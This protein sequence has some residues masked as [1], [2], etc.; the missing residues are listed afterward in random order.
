LKLSAN[1]P[2]VDVK[3]PNTRQR[4]LPA[5]TGLRFIAAL[6]VFFGH[7]I[8]PINPGNPNLAAPFRDDGLTATLITLT[9]PAT[10]MAM[11]LF[12][13]LS[14]FVIT[15]SFKP[16]QRTTSFWRRRVVKIFPS[17]AVTWALCMLLFAGAYTANYG[18]LNLF[19]LDTW[20]NE[21][22]LWGGANGPAWSLNSE[23][24]FYLLIPLLLLP[25][26][27][28]PES[29]L[30]LSAGVLVALYAGACLFAT[31]VIPD[32]PTYG[33]E[34]SIP[35]FWFVYFFPPMRMFEFLLGVLV[36][37]I[38]M[39]GRWPRIPVAIVGALL[40]GSYLLIPEVP[41][42]YRIALV[43]LVPIALAIG[44]L[45]SANLRGRRTVLGTGPM[46]W[47]GRVSFGFYMTQSAVLLGLRY[48]VLPDVEF[49]VVGGTLLILG[50]LAVNLFCG[51]LL[52]IGVELP[53][54]KHW[55]RSKKKPVDASTPRADEPDKVPAL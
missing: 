55:S 4:D 33:G 26:R 52:H 1:T 13:M 10:Y 12:F 20:F 51:W 49:G 8:H 39:S 35:Q 50:L 16:G 17:H 43:A 30:W 40:V 41:F 54:M 21:L 53:A 48:A 46:E 19:F 29:K 5:L 3:S 7:V 45:A 36:A 23:M 9:T 34:F 31:T 32:T 42:V 6:L 14:G 37:R 24:L 25:I 22:S 18:V 44:N 47:L 2:L 38:V 27:R 28:I 11:T 15:W